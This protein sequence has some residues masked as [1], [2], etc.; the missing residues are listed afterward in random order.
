MGTIIKG[1]KVPTPRESALNKIK[2][3]I[4]NDL[5]GQ[6]FSEAKHGNNIHRIY[7]L[8]GG[9]TIILVEYRNNRNELNG[10]DVF[11]PS[12]EMKTDDLITELKKFAAR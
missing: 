9:N 7:G 8:N 10:C 3:A 4:R 5:N 2:D 12:R 1:K 11:Y 6:L